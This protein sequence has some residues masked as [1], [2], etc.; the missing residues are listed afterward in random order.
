MPESTTRDH[1]GVRVRQ[2]REKK[3][4]SLSDLSEQAHI[5]R[6]YLHQIEQGESTPTHDKI[7]KLADALGVLVS[8]LLG[9]QPVFDNV[10][11][12]LEKFAEQSGLESAEIRML[13]QI[14][15]RG[16][17]PST[18]AEWRAIYWV[19]RGMLTEEER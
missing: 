15:Y 17:R 19:I 6:S 1:I 18:E 10:P 9:E 7:Q 5:S 4:W 8:D 13:A 11:E 3:D 16:K 12:S 14:Q 2:L